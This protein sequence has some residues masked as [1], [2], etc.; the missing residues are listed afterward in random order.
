VFVLLKLAGLLDELE[1]LYNVFSPPPL[2]PLRH[3]S[4]VGD[5]LQYE[6]SD[7]SIPR[8]G[9][10]TQPP[11]GLNITKLASQHQRKVS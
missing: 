3:T 11:V 5:Q 1:Y 8:P 9:I 4:A 6:K 10:P 2:D 7:P